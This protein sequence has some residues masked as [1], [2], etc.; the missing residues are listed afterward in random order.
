[1][2]C[3]LNSF[4]PSQHAPSDSNS[5]DLITLEGL[6]LVKAV[7]LQRDGKKGFGFSLEPGEK[8]RGSAAAL[9]TNII[10]GGPAE[11]DGN[12]QEG[13]QILS[14]DGQKVLGY[15]YEKVLL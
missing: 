7:S 13:D 4:S 14:I 12:L 5:S 10:R 6:P 1:M 11:L 9:V 8:I 15:A 3:Y 2:P